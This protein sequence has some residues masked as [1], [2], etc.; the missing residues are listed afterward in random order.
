[1]LINIPIQLPIAMLIITIFLIFFFRYALSRI[2]YS[3]K[4]FEIIFIALFTLPCLSF[5]ATVRI[6]FSGI[7]E[8]PLSEVPNSVT[9][10]EDI[11]TIH[12][13]PSGYTY[14]PFGL[15][16]DDPITFR[17]SYNEEFKTGILETVKGDRYE[18]SD[19]DSDYIKSRQKGE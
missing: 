8:V 13:L 7:H 15:S 6:F 5:I 14:N 11:V 16:G 12:D 18:L 2:S 9:V 3:H 1:M 10:E 17:Y 19:E 4:Y